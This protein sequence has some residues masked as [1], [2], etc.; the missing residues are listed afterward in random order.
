MKFCQLTA[1]LKLIREYLTFINLIL[2]KQLFSKKSDNEKIHKLFD[3]LLL[4]KPVT[5][6]LQKQANGT[7]IHHRI[8]LI[9]LLLTGFLLEKKKTTTKM[10]SKKSTLTSPKKQDENEILTLIKSLLDEN[11]VHNFLRVNEF[12]GITYFNK[13]RFEELLRWILLLNLTQ[14]P[15]HLL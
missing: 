1:K 11:N 12:E 4:S 13:E 3:E 2:L 9:Q 6:I 5:H 15:S 14:I 8:E 10:V 7:S